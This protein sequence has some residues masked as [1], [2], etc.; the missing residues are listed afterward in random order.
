MSAH[1]PNRPESNAG[2]DRREFL[3]ATGAGL[4]AAVV[5]GG[6]RLEGATGMSSLEEGL[7]GAAQASTG[8]KKKIP[9]GVFDPVY[10]DLS[11][12]AMI[13]KISALGL[14]AVEIGTGGYPGSA[15]CPV[16]ELLESPAKAKAWVKKFED[17]RIRVATLSC[18][19]NP[20]HPDANHAKRDIES[21]QKTVRLA[22]IIGVK[23][24]VGFSGCPGGSPTET[25]PNWVTYRWPEEYN[26]MLEWQWKEKVVPYWKEAAKYA[27]DHGIHRL[28]FEM[29][30][31]FVVYN[32][33]TLLKLREAVGEEIGANCDLS[34]LFWQGCDPVEVIHFLGK[35]GMIYH[36]H[37]KDTVL[38]PENVAR[39]G[40]LN[41]VFEKQ[42]LPLASDAFR[43]VG[44][45]HGAATWKR[46]VQAYM[47]ID[48]DGIMSIENEDPILSGEAG[49]ERAAYVL[50]NVR[51][52]ILGT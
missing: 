37:M 30:P 48:Y 25:Q 45:G 9:I 44:Y 8:A 1:R 26:Q 38:Y 42:D 47:D 4:I 13:D 22:Q 27:R 29:H 32:P 49:V 51:N 24:I 40:V 12:D 52:E 21:F 11:L 14:E 2:L 19:G 39:Y 31:N 34:H 6:S 7:T 33:R 41:F 15:H 10:A 17:R 20:I 3:T 46:I 5:P 23:V 50:K 28:A 36:A 43:A 18:H 35:Q 16:D